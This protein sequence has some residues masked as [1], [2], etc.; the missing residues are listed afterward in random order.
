MSRRLLLAALALA[1]G[2]GAAE[3]AVPEKGLYGRR[4]AS[5]AFR[6]DALEEEAYL[7]RITDLAP[8]GRLTEPAVGAALRNLFATRR[9]LDLWV[10]AAPN[11]EDVDVVLAFVAAPKVRSVRLV[12]AGLPSRSRLRD[13][14]GVDPGDLW[15]AEKAEEADRRVRAV[16]RERGYFEPNVA[17][18]VGVPQDDESAVTVDVTVVP[19]PR[20]TA[21]EPAWD[22]SAGDVPVAD[23]K[24]A[25]RLSPGRPFREA[26]ARDDAGRLAELLR[27]RGFGR[28]EVRFAGA[29]YAAGAR[30]ATPRYSLFAG[31]RTVL[32][33]AGISESSVRR[34]PESPW[35]KGDPPDEESLKRLRDAL[36][37]TLQRSGHARARV[38]VTSEVAP[39]QETIRVRVE[40]G[41][42]FAV[43]RVGLEGNR[44]VPARELRAALST[45][46]RG[47]LTTGRLVD[48]DLAADREAIASLYRGRGFPDARVLAPRV[49]E[50]PSPSTLEVVLPVE[51]GPRAVTSSRRVVG[52]RTVASERLEEVLSV[53][54]GQPLLP[55][56]LAADVAALRG[57]YAGRG[58]A[59]LRIDAE[60]ERE[61]GGG[62]AERRVSVTY[63]IAEGD[64]VTFGKTVI[65]GQRLTRTEVVER[66]LAYSEGEPFSFSKVVETQQKLSRLDVFS[67]VEMGGFPSEA[68]AP[69]RTMLLTLA[70]AKPW[71]VT[72]GVGLEYDSGA[73]RELNPRLSL[74][75]TYGNLFGR[76]LVVGGEARYSARESRLLLVA[77][78]RD[79]LDWGIPLSVSAYGAEEARADFTVRRAGGF[80]DTE[81]RLSSKVKATLRYQYEITEPSQDPGL[82]PA[83]RQNQRNYTSSLGPGL[84]WDTRSDPIDP[85][86]GGL[87][88]S[89]LKWAFPLLTA[90]SDFLKLFA[91]GALYR[92]LGATT[93]ALSVRAG[94][95]ES[96]KACDEAAGPGCAPNLTVP[97][98]ERF[99]AGG[100]ASHRAFGLDQLG[101]PGQTVNEQG[102]AYG[103]N[104]IFVANAEWR[105]PVY[106]D[107]RGSVFVDAG[108][109]WA[110]WR[111]VRL[112]QLRWGAG[113]GLS[114]IT[115]VGPL[116]V[117]Y[118]WKLDREPGESAGEFHFSVGYP[119]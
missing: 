114:Y 8:G 73:T 111:D 67:R 117:E 39:G 9:F 32:D 16:L 24:A 11:G 53:R 12:G 6:G 34:H 52:A 99:F 103:G 70:E 78:E 44:S 104:G 107:L 26:V 42:R 22:G 5:L 13:A 21:G 93:L 80:A 113:L 17:V 29:E 33:V 69:R 72:Y 64:P 14:V 89:E 62:E 48:R 97:I 98:V 20:A 102:E 109:V 59:D 47:L 36:L 74:G 60:T 79:F 1:G 96:W 40:R 81:R 82:D 37:E 105:F 3:E 19:G 83:E 58:I 95:T 115:P 43:A 41:E 87:V 76:A 101:I 7:A 100:R 71:S 66:Q 91:Q 63:R 56:A 23:L 28:A 30:V 2:L 90:D 61:E 55:S 25:L 112:S 106:G 85:R 108:N 116:R 15:S 75:V 57:L 35:S 38:E 65:R 4:I 51:E 118:G 27:K 45:S 84:T 46:P 94:L 86:S 54:P 77:R 31:P 119:F 50:G 110:D 49:S 88:V 92:P 18:D 10:E 68:D